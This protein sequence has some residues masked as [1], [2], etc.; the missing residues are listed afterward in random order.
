MTFFRKLRFSILISIFLVLLFIA[1]GD[2]LRHP[3]RQAW[4]STTPAPSTDRI[5]ILAPHPDDEVLGCAGIIQRARRNG[6]PVKIVFLTY[7]DNNQWSFL[8]YRKHFVL[9][10]KAVRLMGEMRRQ[11]GIEAGKILGVDEQDLIFLGY[12]DFKTLN[13]W[14]T[15]WGQSSPIKSMLTHVRAVPYQTAFRPGAEY[16]GEDILEDLKSIIRDFKPTKIFVSH[17][18]DHNPDHRSLYLFTKVALFDLENEL[19]PALNPY[20]IHYKHWPRPAGY[21]PQSKL[22]PPQALA[23]EISWR[24]ITLTSDEIA[25]K[26]L[27]IQKHHSQF[28]SSPGYLLSFVRSPELF[29]DFPDIIVNK[30]ASGRT[31]TKDREDDLRLPPEELE[32]EEIAS[33]VGIEKRSVFLEND[34]LVITLALSRPLGKTVGLSLFTFG[35]KKDVPFKDMPK[36]RIR[37][38]TLWHK[39]FDQRKQIKGKGVVIKR[40]AKK[41][42]V[43]IP[44]DLLGKPEKIFTSA[45]TY[46]GAVPL[47][48]VS[49]RILDLSG[50]K[51]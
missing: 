41:I 38:G 51:P 34:C 12:P 50:Q 30:D 13:I 35:Y 9:M 17:P 7:G 22:D 27:A 47:D 43:R 18:A 25:I 31:L 4:I 40:S 21:Y 6:V 23:D 44:L 1:L 2:Y 5:L 28:I 45:N 11:E 8:V 15:N 3:S 36:I 32:D 46:L 16:K 37:F 20:L 14:Y 24:S 39:V 48:W 33:F 26:H 49:W 19:R 42:T 10:P 29:G